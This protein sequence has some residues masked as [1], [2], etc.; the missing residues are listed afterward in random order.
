LQRKIETLGARATLKELSKVINEA[1]NRPCKLVT[2]RVVGNGI[3]WLEAQRDGRYVVELAP[4][5]KGQSPKCVTFV[6]AT[7]TAFSQLI[8]ASHLPGTLSGRH[9]AGVC[10][11]AVSSMYQIVLE[12]QKSRKRK[13]NAGYH[14]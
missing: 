10:C 14:N 7:T 1:K 8:D 12:K 2:A 3:R 6:R 13:G 5:R 11:S 4:N 9:D